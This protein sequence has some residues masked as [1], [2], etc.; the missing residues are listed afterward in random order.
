[1]K[2]IQAL[3][4]Q[5][6]IAA[7]AMMALVNDTP[8]DQW[9]GD[10]QA[11]YD[12]M[13]VDIEKL[14]KE[15]ERVEKAIQLVG[16][17]RDAIDGLA[18]RSGQRR[19]PTEAEEERRVGVFN[20]WLR[21]GAKALSQE[22]LLANNRII[23]NA[24]AEGTNSAGGY[25]V[26]TTTVA[27][28]LVELKAYGGM[29][30]VAQILET[31]TG[32]QMNW[33]T[34]DDTSNTGELI[35]ENTTATSQ[36]LTFGQ[37]SLSPYKFSSKIFAVPFELM[38]DSVVDVIDIVNKAAG[39]RLGRA[40]NTYFTTGSGSSQPKGVVTAAASGR[41]GTTGQTASVIYDD[42]VELEHSIDPAYRQSGQCSW[43]FHDTTLKVLKKLKDGQSRPLWLPG[44]AGMDGPMSR[45]SLLGY[46]YT[47]NQ[48]IATM[49]ANA[50]SILFGTFNQY[51]IR[52]VMQL[53]MFR[54]DD[55]AYIKLG[56]IGFLAWM[57][58]GGNYIASSNSSMKY[59]ANSAT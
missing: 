51:M 19:G 36:D 29:R 16:A 41:V 59:Y 32:E 52:D 56:Q 35:A 31:S 46:G 1:M 13:L 8:G 20:R 15:I 23:R 55:S 14:D 47:I 26:P 37:A 48:D 30:S 34:V 12:K 22:E 21:D 50:K 3:R 38:Q 54:F 45:P 2:S 7:T 44:L 10:H 18:D 27:Q 33:P 17:H 4:E 25:L 57:R 6:N 28:L 5:R 24:Q 40:Q 9:G 43:M 39:V 42:L 49:A 11:K 53:L 58:A